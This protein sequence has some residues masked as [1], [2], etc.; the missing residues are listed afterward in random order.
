MCRGLRRVRRAIGR[1]PVAF[2]VVW[3]FGLNGSSV[4]CEMPAHR[5]FSHLVEL[6]MKC[7]AARNALPLIQSR[8]PVRINWKKSWLLF[9]VDYNCNTKV[10]TWSH[11]LSSKN[12]AQASVNLKLKVVVQ[13]TKEA[14]LL[15]LQKD[16]FRLTFCLL[17]LYAH[18][19][20]LHSNLITK[21]HLIQ[22][23][24]FISKNLL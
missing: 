10:L 2:D 14:C 11:S 18:T 8:C 6:I 5:T 21:F 23:E 1:N 24:L 4:I 7:G 15:S 16:F 19:L 20:K 17:Q 9:S 13:S 12:A 3:R 22:D